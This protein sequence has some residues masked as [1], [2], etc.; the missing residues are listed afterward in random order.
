MITMRQYAIRVWAPRFVSVAALLLSLTGAS[1]AEGQRTQSATSAAAAKCQLAARFLELTAQA[2]TL[3]DPE[4]IRL[5]AELRD[6]ATTR[7][8]ACGTLGTNA[9]ARVIRVTRTLTDVPALEAAV[10]GYLNLRDTAVFH[11][12]LD[13]AGDRSASAPARVFALR[14][15]WVLRTGKFWITYDRML[16]L[17][18]S[19]PS[20][21]VGKCERGLTMAD[22]KP[23]WYEGAALPAGFGEQ[24]ISFAGQIWR[25]SSQPTVVRAAAE[26]ALLD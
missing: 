3:K 11:A 21:V 22:G 13:V 9:A 18:E 2:P 8:L 14:T 16:P 7:L 20:Y 10:G 5:L 15:L 4:A 12:A 19:T 1:S 17:P 24:I 23:F 6:V 25:D 26:C